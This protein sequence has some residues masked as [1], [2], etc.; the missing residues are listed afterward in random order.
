MQILPI[1]NYVNNKNA[2]IKK[3]KWTCVN[4]CHHPDFIELKRK[5]NTNIIASSY[6]RR[7]GFYGRPC[8]EFADVIDSLKLF[9]NEKMNPDKNNKVRMMIGGI[10]YSQE[11]FSILAVVKHIIGSNKLD[12]VLDL[13]IVD[14]QS[15]PSKQQLFLQS[16]YEYNQKPDF[17]PTSF[18]REDITEHGYKRHRYRVKDDIV[19]YLLDV[20]NNPE[21]AKWE[22][23]IQD[24]I[25][26][27]PDNSFDVVSVNNTL[28]YILDFQV[29]MFVVKNIYKMLKPNGIFITDPDYSSYKKVFSPEVSKEIYPGIYQKTADSDINI[30]AN[31]E[32]VKLVTKDNGTFYITLQ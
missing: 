27:Y 16:F 10:A 31:L 21:K 4:F 8:K 1:N 5:Y 20:Y 6:F 22:T 9:F 26:E 13:N 11:P 19:K 15:K 2:S 24:A 12:E 23:R 3:Q 29:V 18:V 14:L 32:P 28:G 25:N 30:D 17:V 7:G